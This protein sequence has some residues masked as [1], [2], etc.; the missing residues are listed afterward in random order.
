MARPLCVSMYE[1]MDFFGRVLGY[2]GTWASGDRNI[3]FLSVVHKPYVHRPTRVRKGHWVG[4][5]AP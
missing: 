2:H 5:S 1:Y 3:D 4:G